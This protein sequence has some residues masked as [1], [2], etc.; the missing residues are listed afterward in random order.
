MQKLDGARVEF[1]LMNN[2]VLNVA[3]KLNADQAGTIGGTKK[4]K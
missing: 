4:Q 2:N 1:H 3:H